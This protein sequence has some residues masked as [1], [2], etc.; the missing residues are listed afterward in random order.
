MLSAAA[1]TIQVSV[2]GNS[3]SLHDFGRGSGDSIDVNYTASQI[4]LTGHSG[5]QFKVGGS[6]VSTY[7]IQTG[8]PVD[9]SIMLGSGTNTLNITGDGTARL[10]SLQ[11]GG[12]WRSGN[13]SVTLNHVNADSLRVN[14]GRGNDALSLQNS[15]IN[16]PLRA[17][18]GR[19][20]A[21]SLVMSHSTVN[22]DVL[23]KAHQI[24][25]DHATVG[26][27]VLAIQQGGT[28]DA[29]ASTF[30][31]RVTDLMGKGGTVNLH[32]ST[33][34]PNHFHDQTVL[35]GRKS[36]PVTLNTSTNAVVN[37]VTPKLINVNVHNVNNLTAPT[38]QSVSAGVPSIV[39]GTWDS[40]HAQTLNVTVA[41]TTYQLGRDSQLTSPSAGNWSLNL[42]GVHLPLGAT[43]VT[44]VN[45]DSFGNQAQG[46]GTVTTT[47]DPAQLASIRTYLAANH[48]TAQQTGS[49][50][51]YVITTP[52]T[53]SVPTHNQRVTV[54]YSGFLLNS[55]G[56]L[57]TEFDSNVDA[58]FNHVQP[59]TFTLGAGQVIA[60]WDEAFALLPVGTVAKL[61]IPSAIAYGSRGQ[62][63]IPANSIL[64]FDITLVS[65]Q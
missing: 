4:T 58:Q 34:G 54:N 11:I 63:N 33:D 53:G 44:A 57:G 15:T 13:S 45:S 29:T 51:N 32:Q 22:G 39:T 27:R 50:L 3:V 61:F 62:G 38:V 35:I 52:G 60:G 31:G 2:H 21:D 47:T 6:T 17:L 42:S 25:A 28:L 23:A 65:A 40:T 48:L 9:L 14:G 43:T 24:T 8:H 7:T 55:D 64:E 10:A 36:D 56:T 16:G 59:F 37:D 18:L 19:D 20:Q 1:N 12:G 49:G 46:T 41:G 30:N 26:G 5:T